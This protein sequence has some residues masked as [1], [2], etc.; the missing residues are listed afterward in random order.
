MPDVFIN[1][2]RYLKE[3]IVVLL[4][5]TFIAH[6]EISLEF[7]LVP[8]GSELD[9]ILAGI[10]IEM[11]IPFFI[12]LTELVANTEQ[13]KSQIMITCEYLYLA[14]TRKHHLDYRV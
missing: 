2:I 13:P 11:K 9:R 10:T 8:L 5:N 7:R 14:S 1:L 6:I 12:G 3:S 4:R